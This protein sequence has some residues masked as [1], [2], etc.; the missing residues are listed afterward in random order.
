MATKGRY[1]FEKINSLEKL[2]ICFALG[3]IGYLFV[4]IDDMYGLTR[5]MFA[6]NIFSLSM[7]VMNWITFNITDSREIRS[8]VQVQDP[9]RAIVFILILI[10]TIASVLAVVMMII[11]KNVENS[12]IGW[13]IP[14]AI[15][16]MVLSWALIHTLFAL[17]YAHIYYG[18]DVDNPTNHAGGLN[19]PGGKR[20]EYL[21]FAYFSFV[22]GMTFQVSDVEIT[23]RSLRTLALFHSMIS[24]AY[25]TVMI[26]LVINLTV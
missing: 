6:W 8:Q 21:D 14:L 10:A 25:N 24:F 13:R 1:W 18:N 19:F 2:L 11:A 23:S 26:A 3:I 9:K 17:R 4:H 12:P 20:P 5:L 15:A 16:G 7:I 22:L